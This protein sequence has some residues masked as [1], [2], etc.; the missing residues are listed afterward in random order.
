MSWENYG[1]W[2]GIATK[3]NHSWDLDHIVP[4]ASAICEEDIIRLNHYTN[5]QP[6]CSY[7]NRWIK[8]ANELPQPI[9]PRLDQKIAQA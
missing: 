2:S 3:L 4:L 7:T 8:R 9:Y 6:L 1:N 5:F